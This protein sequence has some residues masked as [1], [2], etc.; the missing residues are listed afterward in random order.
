MLHLSICLMI[1]TYSII[2]SCILVYVSFLFT[3][4]IFQLNVQAIFK[5]Y[6]VVI[7]SVILMF[8]TEGLHDDHT[9]VQYPSHFFVSIHLLIGQYQFGLSRVVWCVK[10]SVSA[11]NINWPGSADH[12]L[13][14]KLKVLN[15]PV[16][17]SWVMGN[18]S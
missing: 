6:I 13:F 11:D 9:C 3:C 1:S 7:Y 14:F 12:R 16:V 15:V 4:M 10:V 8:L 2:I 17:S 18:R 5:K